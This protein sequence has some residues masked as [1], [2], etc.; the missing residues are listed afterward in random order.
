MDEITASWAKVLRYYDKMNR[1]WSDNTGVPFLCPNLDL[2]GVDDGMPDRLREM[3]KAE[4]RRVDRSYQSGEPFPGLL[5]FAPTVELSRTA[6]EQRIKLAKRIMRKHVLIS[7]LHNERLAWIMLRDYYNQKFPT[8]SSTFIA[9]CPNI[10]EMA[11]SREI[12]RVTHKRMVDRIVRNASQDNPGY[13]IGCY[14][15]GIAKPYE[16]R[17][18]AVRARRDLC[19]Q[20]AF[21]CE[22]EMSRLETESVGK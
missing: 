1:V 3:I 8:F 12:N 11:E 14:Y 15:P 21:V 4:A 17:Q 20:W 16:C 19:E 6:T 9:M 13:H 5:S 22:T 10:T 18:N 7:Q 2:A